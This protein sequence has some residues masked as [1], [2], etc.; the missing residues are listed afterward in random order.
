MCEL[1][2]PSGICYPSLGDVHIR[3]YSIGLV[4]SLVKGF[5]IYSALLA[6]LPRH[7]LHQH[8][9]VFVELWQWFR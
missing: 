7:C 6:I 1:V 9:H 5:R 4:F 3:A 8:K 2:S